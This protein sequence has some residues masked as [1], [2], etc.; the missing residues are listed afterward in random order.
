MNK[1]NI[2]LSHKPL[3]QL[4][5][6]HS[7][8]SSEKNYAENQLKKINK[9]LYVLQ[10][11]LLYE[12]NHLVFEEKKDE[13]LQSHPHYKNNHEIKV[14]WEN[15]FDHDWMKFKYGVRMPINED[16]STM[17]YDGP[18][19]LVWITCDECKISLKKECFHKSNQELNLYKIGKEEFTRH[20]LQQ[21]FNEYKK[22]LLTLQ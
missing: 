2:L 21:K 9:D 1:D 17:E 13:L 11:D 20:I 16:G 12:L 15:Y 19:I 3:Q 4:F 5:F 7:Y 18:N 6:Q 8:K 14:D 10:Q 22:Q